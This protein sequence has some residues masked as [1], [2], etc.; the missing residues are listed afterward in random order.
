[1]AGVRCVGPASPFVR[2]CQCH[3]LGSV[4]PSRAAAAIPR[5]RYAYTKTDPCRAA[6]I[7]ILLVLPRPVEMHKDSPVEMHKDSRARTIPP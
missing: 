6:V 7:G 3:D 2:V 1:M 5:R 4:V